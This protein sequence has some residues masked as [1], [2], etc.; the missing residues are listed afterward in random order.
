ME[1]IRSERGV[2]VILLA[3][4][5]DQDMQSPRVMAKKVHLGILVLLVD[6]LILFFL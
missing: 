6:P 3:C 4:P 2:V 1:Q 5:A